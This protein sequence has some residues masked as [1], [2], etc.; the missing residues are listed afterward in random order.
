MGQ[1]TYYWTSILSILNWFVLPKS[2]A[3]RY[4]SYLSMAQS[5][6]GCPFFTRCCLRVLFSHHSLSGRVGQVGCL[7]A[8]CRDPTG[9]LVHRSD[10]G[11][12]WYPSCPGCWQDTI[13]YFCENIKVRI[14][15]PKLH[16][17]VMVIEEYNVN[18]WNIG[19]EIYLFCHGQK[20]VVQRKVFR[21]KD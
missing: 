9:F 16:I 10:G 21:R 20:V 8:E 14:N 3:I 12:S 4:Q 1:K 18:E 15:R 11:L 7:Q 6:W 2:E 5:N 19:I 17:A 13:Y